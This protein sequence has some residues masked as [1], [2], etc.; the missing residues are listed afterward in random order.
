[1]THIAMERKGI[2]WKPIY[3][4]LEDYFDST[5]ANAQ[6]I[7]NVPG[8]KTDVSDAEWIAKLLRH[9]LIEKS[10]VP[11]EDIRELRNLT[12]LRT[13]WIGHMT[14]E[15][16]RIQKVLE[17][18]L[19][20]V[21]GKSGRNLLEHIMSEGYIDQVEQ[22]IHGRMSHKKGQI[23]DS[24]CGTLTDHQL[25]LIK[26]SWMHLAYLENLISDIDKRIDQLL[27]KY[28]EEVNL[29]ITMPGIKKDTAAIII[30]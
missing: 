5:L 8:C 1:V 2:Y 22:H 27:E 16:N 21:F 13:K 17:S 20:T 29:L 7:K 11:P 25:F 10:L 30:A 4:I 28:Q 3:N 19:G 24:L 18:S 14:S 12:R 6:R 26:Q 9:G 23:A 15:K